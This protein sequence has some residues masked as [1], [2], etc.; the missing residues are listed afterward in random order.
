MEKK[1]ESP[2]TSFKCDDC[3]AEVV[4][5]GSDDYQEELKQRAKLKQELAQ[6]KPIEKPQVEPN[7]VTDAKPNE[8]PKQPKETNPQRKLLKDQI[9]QAIQENKATQSEN[10]PN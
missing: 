5:I 6:M 9:A 2:P 1:E 3:Q 7:Q 4:V 8:V 10:A